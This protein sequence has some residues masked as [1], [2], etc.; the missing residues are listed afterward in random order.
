[1]IETVKQREAKTSADNAWR[2]RL[3]QQR[4][5]LQSLRDQARQR[6]AGGAPGLQVAALICQM[7]DKL[8]C[9]LFEAALPRGPAPGLEVIRQQVAVVAVGGTGRGELAPYSD[10]DLLFLHDPRCET[11]LPGC[12]SQVVRDCW[13]AGIKLGHSVR[14]PRDALAAA[15][16]DPQFATALVESRLLWGSDRLFQ[17][18]T[19]RFRRQ[20]GRGR[21][22]DFYRAVIASREAER[23]QHGETERQLEPDLKRSAGGLRDI[24]LIRWIGFARYGTPDISLLRLEGALSREDEQ[25]LVEA[26]EFLTRIRVDLHFAAGKAQEILTRE[27]Q[28]RLADLHGVAATAGQRPVERFMQTLFRHT[29]AVVDIASRFADR[30]RPVSPI[31]RVWKFV[32]SHRSNQIYVVSA[33]EIDVVPSCRNLVGGTLEAQLH[34][35]ELAAQYSVRLAPGLVELIRQAAPRLPR[36]VSPE[37]ARLFLSILRSTSQ[38]GKQLREMYRTG[39]LEVVMPEMTHARCLLQFNQY[40]AYT[41]DEHSIRAVEAAERFA[42]DAGPLG[43]ACRSIKHR[44]LLHLALL[45]HDLG[46]GYEGDHSEVGREIAST[47]A[48]RLGLSLQ[49]TEMLQFLVHKHLLM[50]HLAFRRDL[51]EMPMLARFSRD[52]GSPELLRMLYVLSA[53]DIAAVGPGAWTNWKSELLTELFEGAQQILSGAPPKFREAERTREISAQV[54]RLLEARPPSAAPPKAD[55]APRLA[56]L[57]EML[58]SLPLHYL[59]AAAPEQIVRDLVAISELPSE[60]V[61]VAGRYEG[62]TGTVEYRIVTRDTVGSGLFHKITGVLTAKGLEILSAVICTT[63]ERFVIDSFRV[64]DADHAGEVPS[65]RLREVESSVRDVLQGR[66]TVEELFARHRR[67][68]RAESRHACREPTRVVI[69]NDSSERFTVIDVFADDRRGLLYTIASSLLELG[70]SVSLA[71]IA[72]HVDQVLDVFYVTDREGSKLQEGGRLLEIQS[73]LR[74]RIEDF[75]RSG[76]VAAATAAISSPT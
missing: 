12:I 38:V 5:R 62:A 69:D 49:Q 30:H 31:A 25:A 56:R 61:V 21:F 6:Y 68:R 72:T 13:D 54:R 32:R 76:L 26:H 28:L 46:K 4:L 10:V 16:V 18:F 1:M 44:D 8:V 20:V 63:P 75:E 48:A 15:R 11:C 55:Q 50:A 24:H 70:L 51:S 2:D 66:T 39:L 40:H 71:K 29:T 7:T 9:E 36:T 64:H 14:T 65:F 41:V 43:T 52:V 17:A 67:L 37:A 74:S 22:A 45:L 42:C 57:G 58:D 34:L 47:V 60:G 27:E 35:I 59:T 53:S 33:N 73:M 3:A 23:Q 19:S